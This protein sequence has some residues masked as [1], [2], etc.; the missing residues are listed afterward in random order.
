[1]RS[2]SLKQ[3]RS[4]VSVAEDLSF[5]RAGTRLG[6]TQPTLSH[7]IR[8]LEEQI[9]VSLFQRFRG[10]VRLTSAG[11][12]LLSGARKILLDYDYLVREADKAGRAETG[13]LALG[14]STS[15]VSG[16]LHDVVSSYRRQFRDV[17]ILI[18]EGSRADQ[19][20]ALHDGLIDIALVQGQVDSPR[21]E[22][23]GIAAERLVVALPSGHRL[24]DA[25]SITWTA[26]GKECLLVRSLNT[27]GEFQRFILTRAE[28]ERKTRIERH[29]VGRETLLSLV[30]AGFGIAVVPEP[31]G[32]MIFPGV[33]FRAM[34]GDGTSYPLTLAWLRENANP[35]L[36]RFVSLARR[37]CR[38]ALSASPSASQTFDPT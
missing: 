9:G 10:G 35:V 5:R 26:G 12:N 7:H 3:L 38:E 27:T 19:I 33:T 14:I 36:R 25:P 28:I 1:M 11:R 13:N 24:V 23:L 29:D 18:N 20:S 17:A 6:V 30:S 2:E 32:N 22:S 34:D 31:T 15:L 37:H 4:F 21:T 16:P 8:S